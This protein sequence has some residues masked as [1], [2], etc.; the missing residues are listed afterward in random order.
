MHVS[1][2]AR[3]D[4]RLLRDALQRTVVRLGGRVVTGPARLRSSS[5]ASPTVELA[6]E[7][8]K[9]EAVIVAAGAWTQEVVAPLGAA[10]AIEP[11]RGQ[12]LHLA[13]PGTTTEEFPVLSGYG[14]DYMVTFPPDRVVVGATRETGSGFDYRITAGGVNELLSRALR[15]A[16]GLAGATLAE[17]RVGFRPAT[18]DGRPIRACFQATNGSSW[19]VASGHRASPSAHTLP[20]SSLPPRAGSRC[21]SSATLLQSLLRSRRPVSPRTNLDGSLTREARGATQVRSPRLRVPQ[22]AGAA[23]DP[24]SRV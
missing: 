8:S 4:G 24:Q 3:I 13:L 16:P 5:S 1:G 14:S 12:I 6:N 18:P 11:Q 19:R 2:V 9:A 23:R 7:R 10:V 17:V 20:P 22:L 15:V 21:R